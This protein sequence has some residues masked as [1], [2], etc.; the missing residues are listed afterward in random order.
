M[1]LIALATA[2]LAVLGVAHARAERPGDGKPLQAP[3]P[4]YT[5]EQ[6]RPD[7]FRPQVGALAFLPDGKLAVTSF[8]PA[9]NGVFRDAYNGTLYIIDNPT[10]RDPAKIAVRKISEDLHDPLGMNVVDGVLYLCDRNEVSKWTDTDGDGYPDK[11]ETFSSGW[12]SDN[13]HHFTFG[14]PYH[15]GH[16]YLTLSTNITFSKMIKQENIKG[17]VHAL[18]GPNPADRGCLLKI[19]AK[20]GEYTTVVGGLRTPNGVGI[21]PDGTVFIPDNQGAWKPASGIYAAEQGRFYGH[22]NNT[23]AT[24]DF[25]PDGGVPAAFSDQPI[26]SPAVWLP[27][28]ECA[29]SPGEIITIPEGQPFAG[30]MLMAEV[31]MGGLRRIFVEKVNGRWQGAAFRHSQGFEA[32]L[33]RLAWGPDGCLYVGGMGSGGNWNWKGKKF[34]LQRMR[35]TGETAFEYE[36]IEATKDG[37]RVT[38]TR[39]VEKTQLED[40]DAWAIKAWTYKHTHNYGGPKVGEHRVKPTQAVAGADGMSVE[41]TVP[42][43]KAD[44]IYYFRTD[45][46]SAD[47]DT[48]WATDAWY[49]FHKAP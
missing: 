26:T 32:G 7:D 9:N 23:E 13:Y 40:L 1:R 24:S 36:K 45:P 34:G 49:T 21:G 8:P 11:R 6:A 22:Y 41:L 48:M 27:Q 46:R 18:N 3:H 47:G 30:Q 37:F 31:R 29:N 44:H 2:L 17:P 42:D 4:A 10:E 43:R 35:P 38:F 28:N 5:V 14:L 12:V 15:D 16:F 20:T 25:Y 39:Q 19:D 33:N